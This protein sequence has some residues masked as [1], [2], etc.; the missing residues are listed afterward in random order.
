MEDLDIALSVRRYLYTLLWRAF[1]EEPSQSFLDLLL[2]E[3]GEQA[4]AEAARMFGDGEGTLP[5]L[6]DEM[7]E[8]ARAVDLDDLST[9][10]TRL[11]IGPG[12][13]PA[14]PWASVHLGKDGIMFDEETLGVRRT[15]RRFGFLPAA[16]PKVADDHIAIELNFMA[17]LSGKALDDIEEGDGE[18]VPLLI[19]GMRSFLEDRMLTWLSLFTAK[20]DELDATEAEAFYVAA[21]RFAEKLAQLDDGWLDAAARP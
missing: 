7:R 10:Y 5:A 16:Y 1:S 9:A 19:E 20:L 11:F 4:V 14:A 17:A 6:H 13:L 8:A 21:A 15:Y 3:Y 18:Q 12:K 2:D